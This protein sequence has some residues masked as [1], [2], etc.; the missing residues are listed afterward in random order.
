MGGAH[1]NGGPSVA[2]AALQYFVE[3][4]SV[5]CLIS[6]IFEQLAVSFMFLTLS[7]YLSFEPC[8]PDDKT[9]TIWYHK[10]EI[11][12]TQQ[13]DF[14]RITDPKIGRDC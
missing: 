11:Y 8:H 4:L 6:N 5:T 13:A 1:L 7:G 3:G 10:D 9:S 14:D 2:F 12:S